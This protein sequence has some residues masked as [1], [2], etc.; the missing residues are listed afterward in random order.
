MP[1]FEDRPGPRHRGGVERDPHPERRSLVERAARP[2]PDGVAIFPVSR[3]AARVEAGRRPSH[4]ADR[5]VGREE[6]VERPFQLRR[7]QASL[8]RE[9]D[10]LSAGMHA[11]VRPAG[12]VDPPRRPVA[13]PAQRVLEDPLDRPFP[14]LHLETGE[15]RSVIFDRCAIAHRDALSGAWSSLRPVRS[16]RFQPRHRGAARSGRSGCTPMT[17]PRTWARSRQ[18]AC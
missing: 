13:E 7:R 10:H 2:I 11:G 3:R 16:G 1:A 14:R 12:P 4:P 6:R 15:V 17:G 8:V 9:G 5:D 18:R